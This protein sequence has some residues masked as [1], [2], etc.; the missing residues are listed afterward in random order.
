MRN[1]S[2]ILAVVLITGAIEGLVTNEVWRIL[3][4]DHVLYN[5][6]I[7]HI[8]NIRPYYKIFR[9]KIYKLRNVTMFESDLKYA[10]Y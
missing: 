10:K 2:V 9:E 8:A 5:L 6:N 4:Q 1:F 7:L 3:Q